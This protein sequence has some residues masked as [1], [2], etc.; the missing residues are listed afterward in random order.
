MSEEKRDNE[1]RSAGL[2]SEIDSTVEE[3]AGQA[4]RSVQLLT[5]QI[6]ALARTLRRIVYV[7]GDVPSGSV[8]FNSWERKIDECWRATRQVADQCERA[9]NDAWAYVVAAKHLNRALPH[10]H[11]ARAS[12]DV[13][14]LAADDCGVARIAWRKYEYSSTANEESWLRVGEVVHFAKLSQEPSTRTVA[15]LVDALGIN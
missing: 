5:A 13:V 2:S 9:C 15:K 11:A 10:L 4:G 8:E 12:T 14:Q 3:L 7:P 1:S 6:S